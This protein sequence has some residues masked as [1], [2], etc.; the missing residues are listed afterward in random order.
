MDAVLLNMAIIFVDM[1]I[2]LVITVITLVDMPINLLVN[3]EG[4][5]IFPFRK[6]MDSDVVRSTLYHKIV[7]R[8]MT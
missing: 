2:D 4:V 1:T 8:L 6:L 5:S 3:M 7:K